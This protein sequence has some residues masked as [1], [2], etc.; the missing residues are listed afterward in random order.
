MPESPEVQY[1]ADTIRTCVGQRLVS[2]DIRNGRYKKHGPPT[3]FS[4]FQADLP[5]KLLEVQKKGKVTILVFEK[6]WWLISKLGLTGWWYLEGR[7]PSWHK[8]TPNLTFI[9]G[10]HRLV[11]TDTLSYGTITL[12]RDRKAIEREWGRLAPDILDAATE[13]A[14]VLDRIDYLHSKKKTWGRQMLEDVLM[15]QEAVVSGIGNYLKAEVLYEARISPLRTVGSLNSGDW[16]KI[17]ASARRICKT[18]L[19]HMEDPDAYMGEMRVYMREKDPLGNPVQRHK[20]KSGRTTYW[21]PA[22]Q[23]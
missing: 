11:Y 18:M 2:V 14:I 20:S 15:D 19:K 16:K 21:V 6:G 5:L 4:A 7:A 22:L 23:H 12:T 17:L 13:D 3:H 9:F 8:A 1:V 10:S